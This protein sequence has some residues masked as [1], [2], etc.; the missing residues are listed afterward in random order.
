MIR[1]KDG[2]AAFWAGVIDDLWRMGK[3]RGVGGPWKN[4]PVKVGVASDPYLM[5]GY[6]RKRVQ[7]AADRDA[8]VT[9]E[10]D[11]DGTGVWV[12]FRT[13]ELK[14]GKTREDQFPDGFS[15]YWVR[16]ITDTNCSCT[17]QLVYE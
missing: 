10:I 17:V 14:A 16:A 12:P 5:T 6:D 9:L 8:K 11:I 2:K 7:L 13:Y 3:P 15:A 1:S 4:T